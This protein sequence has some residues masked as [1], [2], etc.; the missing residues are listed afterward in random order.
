MQTNQSAPPAGSFLRLPQII[1]DRK[2]GIVG[3]F[4]VGKTAWY[5]GVKSGKFPQPTRLGPRTVAWHSADIVAL[6]ESLRVSQ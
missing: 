2:R 3:L 4:P 6:I 1:G 5:A